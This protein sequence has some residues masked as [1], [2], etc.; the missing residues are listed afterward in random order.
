MA[1]VGRERTHS[2]F[3]VP[4]ALLALGVLLGALVFGSFFY[5]ARARTSTIQVVGSASERF[6]SDVAKWRLTLARQVGI[7]GLAAGYAQ[8]HV[9]LETVVEHLRSAGIDSSSISIQPV[10]AHQ[11][12]GRE[13][14]REGYNLMQSMYVIS[15]QPDRLEALALNPGSMLAEGVVLEGSYLEYYYTRMAEIKHSLLAKA[16]E[17]A[18]RRASEIAGGEN[19]ERLGKMITGRAGVFQITEPYSTD[20]AAGGIYSTATKEKEISVTVHA[21]FEA[22]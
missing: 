18:R 20:V 21:T 10:N 5:A 13:G 16:T 4:A 22:D 19:G 6:D 1:E 12:W 7:D 15:E 14:V 11:V 2:P 8:I 3:I 17:D 9:D